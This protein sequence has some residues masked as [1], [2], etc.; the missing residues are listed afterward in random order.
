MK[1][2]TEKN[3]PKN[4]FRMAKRIL[5]RKSEVVDEDFRF[6]SEDHFR[7]MLA[8][9][10]KRTERSQKPIIL[11]MLDIAELVNV[12]QRKRLAAQISSVLAIS[13]RDIDVKGWYKSDHIV[14]I[15][16]TETDPERKDLIL[17]KIHV[18]LG[19]SL[20]AELAAKVVISYA[21]FP[22]S[23]ASSADSA[24]GIADVR[25]YPSLFEGYVSKKVS[26][27]L[28]RIVDV[29]GSSLFILLF[30]PVFA[31]IAVIIKL[32]SKGPV[33]FVQ[34]RV[35]RKGRPFHFYKFR[36]MYVGNDS[37][38]HQEYVRKLIQGDSTVQPQGGVYKIVNDPRVTPV[39]R[40]LRKSSLDEIPQFFNVFKGDM[41]LVGPR[42]PIPY[43][44]K[45][46]HMWH[47]RRV[48]EVKPGITGFWQVAGRS[49]TTFDTMVRM[50]LQYAM[51]WSLWWDIRLLVKT[52]LAVFKGAY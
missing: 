18:N 46:Y 7:E 1:S 26:L 21:T 33:F 36:S 52:P 9:E 32:T 22:E 41:S 31:F 16:Y 50:D 44:M 3:I 40:F 27:A 6:Y 10:R 5:G 4:P 39:G 34:T 35:G 28:K 19:I 8:T 12:I 30:L 37:S 25:F 2:T 38:V 51:R 43:E 24:G 48:L 15:I 49:S 11:V 17:Q 23:N 29:V 45:N 47:R 13:S 20:G 14:G 42:P